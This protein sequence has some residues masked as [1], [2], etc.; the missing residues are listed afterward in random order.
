[1]PRVTHRGWIV[2]VLLGAVTA[3]ERRVVAGKVVDASGNPAASVTVHLTTPLASHLQLAAPEALTATTDV[4]GRF[5]AELQV[6]RSYAIGAVGPVHADGVV[7]VS[8]LRFG[9]GAGEFLELQL[10]PAQPPLR[11]RVRG[12]PAWGDD[13]P[14]RVR[15]VLRGA[16]GLHAEVALDAVGGAVLSPL[17]LGTLVCEFLT[18]AGESLGWVEATLPAATPR[19]LAVDVPA[20]RA[21]RMRVR[22][23][24]GQPVARAEV[25]QRTVFVAHTSAGLFDQC[26]REVWR[27]L[28]TT[29]GNGGLTTKVAKS[30]GDWVQLFTA[31]RARS[32]TAIAALI[33]GQP[34]DARHAFDADATELHFELVAEQPLVGQLRRTAELPLANASAQVEV[35]HLLPLKNGGAT[36]VP[37]LFPVTTDERGM[38]RAAAVPVTFVMPRLLADP[39]L[40]KVEG[41]H[42]PPILAEAAGRVAELELVVIARLPAID[43]QVRRA[44]GGP[45]EGAVAVVVPMARRRWFVETW[46]ARHRLDRA[47]RARFAVAPGEA[48]LFCTDGA[49]F[50]ERRID[51]T[52]GTVALQLAPLATATWRITLPN[53]EPAAGARLQLASYS[54]PV[55]EMDPVRQARGAVAVTLHAAWLHD[56]V[57]DARGCAVLRTIPDSGMHVVLSIDHPAGITADLVLSPGDRDVVLKPR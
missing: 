50:A 15:V 35:T 17:P 24:A 3:Q 54:P 34:V 46:D 22:D 49:S 36:H 42:L 28:G 47:G 25:A 14:R 19:E 10:L 26:Q 16:P 52:S 18:A 45:A 32:A 1:M 44:D 31:R 48:L 8:N 20:P 53:G 41:L 5:R 56:L 7:A 43:L 23:G 38:W 11:L 29:D 9:G 55:D 4:H 2:F 40:P 21:L 33:G 57:A 27:S 6:G 37:L 51:E 13:A 12:L 39:R 30:E